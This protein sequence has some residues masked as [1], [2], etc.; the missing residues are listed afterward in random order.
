MMGDDFRPPP[1]PDYVRQLLRD[2]QRQTAMLG[3]IKS[4]VRIA[5]WCIVIWFV[6]T[7]PPILFG[8]IVAYSVVRGLAKLATDPYP[9][10]QLVEPALP[11]ST[12]TFRR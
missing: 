8:G 9:S 10:P 5:T 7:L 12:A 11:S 3:N 2:S 1:A 6:I 4:H